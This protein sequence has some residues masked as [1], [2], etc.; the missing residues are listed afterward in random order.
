V[1]RSSGRP[2]LAASAILALGLAVLTGATACTTPATVVPGAQA[3]PGTPGNGT[4]ATSARNQTAADSRVWVTVATVTTAD[5]SK[6]TVATFHGPV[7]YVLHNGSYE[8]GRQAGHVLEGPKITYPERTR[9]IAAFNG[10]FELKSHA[11]GYEQEG[12]VAWP[13][14]AGLASLVIDQAGHARIGVW[15]Q[16]VPVPGQPA[17]SVRQNLW[18]LV[19]DGQPTAQSAR[20][21]RWGGTVG[22]QEYVARSALGQ[23]AAGNLIYAAGMSTTPAD[24]AQALSESGARVAMELDIN[25][26]WVQLDAAAV[27]GGLLRADI[28]GQHRPATQYLTGWTRDFIAVLAP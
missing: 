6:I 15:G 12:H 13:L 26:E 2:F 18:L 3:T 27:P 25:P 8:P 7:Q 14:K 17:Y 19:S 5:R 9:L 1:N 21:W 20:W 16:G 4:G 23:D 24:L 11:G 22:N 28:P 10:G